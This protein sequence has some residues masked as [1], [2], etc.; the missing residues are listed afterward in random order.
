MHLNCIYCLSL[1]GAKAQALQDKAAFLFITGNKRGLW[2][3]HPQP[4]S[5][6]PPPPLMMM[7][8]SIQRSFC[9]T[10]SICLLSPFLLSP[11]LPLW[12]TSAPSRAAPRP[13]SD[14][15]I[16][17]LYQQLLPHFDKLQIYTGYTS[18]D[19]F[20]LYAFW[21]WHSEFVLYIVSYGHDCK[22]RIFDIIVGFAPLAVV[23]VMR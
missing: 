20:F 2:P 11:S 22:Q 12:L 21:L 18:D 8:K 19:L 14:I 1:N 10:F 23:N 16:T 7:L 13:T 3:R 9:W 6:P 4:R 17:E 15:F 5:P